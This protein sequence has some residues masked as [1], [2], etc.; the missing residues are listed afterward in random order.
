ML[1]SKIQYEYD[2]F[3]STSTF[4]SYGKFTTS[5]TGSTVG[6]GTVTQNPFLHFHFFVSK[7]D[8]SIWF[9]RVRV[10]LVTLPKNEYEVLVP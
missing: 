9:V 7:S 8:Y 2:T 5:T 10:R 4:L 3:T 6:A 1:E